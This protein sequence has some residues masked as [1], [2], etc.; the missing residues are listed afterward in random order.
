VALLLLLAQLLAAEELLM[1]AVREM[2]GLMVAPPAEAVPACPPLELPLAEAHRE[3]EGVWD[4]VLLTEVESDMVT[5]RETEAQELRE[6]VGVPLEVEDTELLRAGDSVKVALAHREAAE[7][8][9]LLREPLMLPVA[10][11][12]GEAPELPEAHREGSRELLSR[13]VAL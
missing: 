2:V 8:P 3:P 13:A 7:L 6:T 12:V 10:L 4:T 9:E 11:E 1:A 5:E